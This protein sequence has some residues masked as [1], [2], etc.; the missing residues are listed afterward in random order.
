MKHVRGAFQRRD[1]GPC[2]HVD[3]LQVV[4]DSTR[5]WADWTGKHGGDRR[6]D[7]RGPTPARPRPRGRE[8]R[9]EESYAISEH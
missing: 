3:M 1:M 2:Y 6:T 4:P 5:K 8:G 7:R 9:N